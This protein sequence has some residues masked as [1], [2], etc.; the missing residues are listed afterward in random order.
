MVVIPFTLRFFGMRD[1]V[2]V[3]F[4]LSGRC[5]F[6]RFFATGRPFLQKSLDFA[7]LDAID[8]TELYPA[9]LPLFDKL[10]D[11]EGM[12]L[13]NIGDLFGSQKVLDHGD[14]LY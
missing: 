12:N 2:I 11:S 5:R 6:G 4:R 10:E 7:F 9:Q 1:V 8:A 3:D 14:T 13:E